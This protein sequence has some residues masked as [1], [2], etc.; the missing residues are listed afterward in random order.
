MSKMR[1]RLLIFSRWFSNCFLHKFLDA[2]MVCM[3]A[4][5]LCVCS[6]TFKCF[7]TSSI[8]DL[9]YDTFTV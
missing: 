9:Q 5:I 4:V 1:K 3:K 7:I 6:F 8:N 2:H